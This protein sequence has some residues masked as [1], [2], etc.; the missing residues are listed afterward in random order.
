MVASPSN[1][2]DSP[3]Y[4]DPCPVSLRDQPER[5]PQLPIHQLPSRLAFLENPKR[6]GISKE[7]VFVLARIRHSRRLFGSYAKFSVVGLTNVVVDYG[8]LNL[9]LLLFPTREPNHLAA[10]NLVA[11]VLA[12]TNSYVWNTRW[13]F[14]SR[15]RRDNH[16]QK[17]MFAAQAV[18]NVGVSSVVLWLAARFLFAYAALPSIVVGDLAK[19]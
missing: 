2:S 17:A 5:Q 13:T 10:Y 15:A 3:F 9:L 12:N 6:C 19:V 18:L 8:T 1:H 7:S 11:L 14:R 16:R 4:E